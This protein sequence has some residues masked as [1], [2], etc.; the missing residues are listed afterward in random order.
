MANTQKYLNH[1]LQ[2][3]GITPACSEEERAAADTIARIFSNHGFE[4]EVQEFTASASRKVAS[5]ALGIAMF[6]SCVLMGLGGALGVMG[7]LLVIACCAVYFLERTGRMS[8]PQIGGGGLSQNVIACHRAS[9][10]LASPRNRPVVVVAHY[11]SPRADLLSRQP[12]AGYRPLLARLQPVAMAVPAAVAVLGLFPLPGAAK[13]V[14]WIAATLLALVPLVQGVSVMLNRFVLPYTSGAVCN[15]SS[16]A[17]MLGVMDAVSPSRAA[18]EFPDDR[19]FDEYMDEQRRLVHEAALHDEDLAEEDGSVE[20]ECEPVVE[21]AARPMSGVPAL[22][23]PDDSESAYAEGEPLEARFASTPADDTLLAEDDIPAEPGAT[24]QMEALPVEE[25]GLPVTDSIEE[26]EPAVEEGPALEGQSNP[27]T[28]EEDSPALPVNAQGNLRFGAD[29]IR[30][31]GMVSDTCSIEYDESQFASDSAAPVAVVDE[32]CD[33]ASVAV[34]ESSVDLG[35][36]PALDLEGDSALAERL[37]DGD[38]CENAVEDEYLEADFESADEQDE[39]LYAEDEDVQGDEGDADAYD[40]YSDD[41]YLDEEYDDG[42]YAEGEYAE[43]EMTLGEDD[44]EQAEETPEEDFVDWGVL[45]MEEQPDEDDVDIMAAIWEPIEDEE[46]DQIS[47]DVDAEED[48]EGT[49]VFDA[50]QLERTVEAPVTESTVQVPALS[51]DDEAAYDEADS[52]EV[53]SADEGS[54][55]V[56]EPVEVSNTLFD[57]EPIAQVDEEPAPADLAEG[58]SEDGGEQPCAPEA[59]RKAPADSTIAAGAAFAAASQPQGTQAS[60]PVLQGTQA[61]PAQ[62]E[63]TVDTVDALMAQINGDVAPQRPLRKINVPSVKGP[64]GIDVPDPAAPASRASLLDLPDPASGVTDPF[65]AP[66]SRTAASRP[67][68][69]SKPASPST[70]QF[71]VISGNT[72]MQAPAAEPIETISAPTPA[73]VKKKR[74]FGGLFGRKKKQR[75]DSMSDWLGVEDD[76]DAKRSGRDIGS[77]DNFDGDDGWKGGATSS[78]DMTEDELRDAVTSMGDDELLG[79]DIWFVAAGASESGNAGIQAFLNTHRD[80][81]RGVFLINLECVGAGHLAMVSTEGER[82]VL[83]GDKRIKGLLSRVS[84]DFHHEIGS[85]DMPYLDTDAHVAMEMSLRSCT[86][87]GVEGTSF[88]FSHSEEDIPANVNA[89]NVALAADIVTEVIRRS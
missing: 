84:A 50:G 14:L 80:R 55:T 65:G 26:Y 89:D 67:A 88:A 39:E 41:G 79:H 47:D 85:V 18:V 35:F 16:V 75:E 57:L 87:A 60:N 10:P 69:P 81:L 13:V 68:A 53:G 48:I 83:K 64:A 1:L 7:A 21:V 27:E 72:G 51:S 42:E 38:D 9:G 2:N 45:P 44:I 61:M 15:K 78:V 6:V 76:F 22:T 52:D 5:A 82:R 70:T 4:P 19:P 11:D 66:V 58:M 49:V 37:E 46:D 34:D 17:A 25:D 33:D 40:E 29:A 56:L 36:E 32:A 8:F 77:W 73:P 59:E 31:L 54:E 74:G 43:D 20:D 71:T 3:V 12:Y 24:V 28:F 23:A 62:P 30:A 86:L 63:R